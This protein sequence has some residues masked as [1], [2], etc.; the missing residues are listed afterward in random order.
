MFSLAYDKYVSE[1]VLRIMNNHK[2]IAANI[3]HATHY[4]LHA[5][6][7]I[8]RAYK[9][10]GLETEATFRTMVDLSGKES[11]ITFI[12][13][14]HCRYTHTR[15]HVYT[16]TTQMYRSD[17]CLVDRSSLLARGN[18]W[19]PLTIGLV[20]GWSSPLYINT[21][22]ML[23]Y[24]HAHTHSHTHNYIHTVLVQWSVNAIGVPMATGTI[25]FA[26]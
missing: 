25:A 23:T 14:W 13:N 17:K 8:R 19:I 7:W 26:M 1:G 15:T 4:T 10:P 5:D 22:S 9:V 18:E 2:T 3:L 16:K 12:S 24:H 21:T 6:I 11:V 20:I